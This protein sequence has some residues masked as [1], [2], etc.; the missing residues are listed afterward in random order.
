[1][2]NMNLGVNL[3]GVYLDNNATTQID[4]LVIEAMQPYF[5]VYF[6]NASSQHGYG[7]PVEKAIIKAREQVADF[8]GAEH[9]DEIIFTSC[10]SE[11]D[12]TALW[13]AL[14]S[15]RGKD[16]IITTPVEHPAIMQTCD[17][18]STHGATIKY[19]KVSSKGDLDLNEFES[20]LSEKTALA[21]VMW[22]NN[23]LLYTSDAADE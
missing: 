14:W 15:Q 19:L 20:L 4:P 1:M 21:S 2:A 9:P 11:S 7:V 10:A 5:S 8:L 16:E 17:F 18:L 23:C 6:G 13:S 12:N 22:A 3:G